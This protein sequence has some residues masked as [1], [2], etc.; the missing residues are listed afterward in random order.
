MRT[1]KQCSI[2]QDVDT[3]SDSNRAYAEVFAIEKAVYFSI[4]KLLSDEC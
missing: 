3:T 2:E 1:K 4:E